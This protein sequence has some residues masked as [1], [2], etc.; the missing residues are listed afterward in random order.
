M[1]VILKGLI[2]T[3]LKNAFGDN[4][5]SGEMEKFSQAIAAAVQKYLQ[6]NV[7][8]IPGQAVLT[9]GGPTNQAGA[10]TAP[11]ILSPQ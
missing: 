6:A 7:T 5:Y 3:E 2:E 10:T 4:L 1:S 11:G 9:A 8:V